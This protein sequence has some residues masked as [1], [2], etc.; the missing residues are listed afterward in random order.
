MR[1]KI[2]SNDGEV[3][4]LREYAELAEKALK[5]VEK[6]KDDKLKEIGKE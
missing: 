3:I 4:S 2:V 5:K 1:I 6:W